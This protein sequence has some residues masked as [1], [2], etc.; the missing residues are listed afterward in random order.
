MKFLQFIIT[1]LL[2]ASITNGA[3]NSRRPP[4][5]NAMRRLTRELYQLDTNSVGDQITINFQG[6]TSSNNQ[7]DLAPRKLF[8]TVPASALRGSTVAALS[9]LLDNY[10]RDVRRP[11]TSNRQERREE[12]QFRSVISATPVM[13]KA[14]QFLAS[15]G[16]TT[17][18]IASVLNTTWF[19]PY[20]RSGNVLGS[21]GFEHVFVGEIKNQG[22]TGF[23]NWVKLYLEESGG[24]ANYYG[25]L[26]KKDLGPKIKLVSLKFKWHGK[27]KN[28]G[29]VFIG[30][31][32]ELEM[33]LY[34]VCFYARPN[35]LCPVELGGQRFNVKTHVFNGKL[36]SAYPQLA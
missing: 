34:T 15:Q 26:K 8:E 2:C 1:F 23:H 24:R 7:A 18:P 28:F 10:N 32:P 25:Y 20:S 29:S 4:S 36:G 35:Q 16:L 21:S 5:A 33:A 19:A 12:T 6:K 9:G 13:V 30:I 22:V 11:E 3:Q 31:S 14:G 17:A 27:M